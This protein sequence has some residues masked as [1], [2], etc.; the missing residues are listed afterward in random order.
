MEQTVRFALPFLVPGQAQKEWFHNEALRRLDMIVAATVEG[1]VTATPPDNPIAGAC[2]LVGEG[3]TGAW[4]GKDGMIAGDGEGG[5]RFVAPAEGM[6]ALRRDNGEFLAFRNGEWEGGI[7]RA[8]EIRVGDQAVV[9]ERQ[10]AITDPAGGATVDT[11]GRAAIT[12][13]LAAMRAHGLIEV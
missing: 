2:Y 11:E 12:A 1:A 8:S 5:W 10:A 7:V 6:R 13:I 9:R 4:V 3:A